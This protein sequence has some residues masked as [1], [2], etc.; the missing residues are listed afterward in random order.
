MALPTLLTYT[1]AIP[2]LHADKP[3]FMANVAALVQPMVDIQNVLSFLASSAF[4][5][6]QAVGVQLDTVGLWIGRS[7]AVNIPLSG[8]YFSF[9]TPNLGFDQGNWQG[10]F[11]PSTGVTL[12]DDTTYRALLRAK[13]IMNSWDGSAAVAAEA[14]NMLFIN[15]PGTFITIQD[16]FDMSMTVGVSGVVPPA[17]LIAL[18]QNGEFNVRPMGVDITYTITSVNTVPLFG[19]DIETSAISGWDVG[20]WSG[21]PGTTPGQVTGF[22]IVA[23]GANTVTLSWIAPVTGVGPYTYQVQYQVTGASTF[24]LAPV[25]PSTVQTIT[26]LAAG[27]SYTAQ[28]YAISSAGPGNPSS[29]LVFSTAAGAPGQV[30]GVQL[31]TAATA[32][33]VSLIWGVVGGATSYQSLYRVTGT[34]PFIIGP[35]ST[36][37]SV[38]IPGLQPATIYDFVIYAV[39]ASGAGINSPVLTVGTVGSAPGVVVNLQTTSV[40]QTDIAIAWLNPTTGNGPF[41]FKVQYAVNTAPIIYQPFTGA[42]TLTA[43]GGSCDITGLING[44]T[45]LIQVS[46]S[47][48]GGNGPFNTPLNVATSVTPNQ[49]TGLTASTTNPTSVVLTWDSIVNA[50]QYQ[51]QYRIE[52]TI[53]WLNG[54]LVTAPTVTATV[55]NLVAGATYQFLVYAIGP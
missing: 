5:L 43:A 41:A 14:I 17:A 51:V 53:V 36:I 45:Y 16:N 29:P 1:G 11:D 6:D 50:V 30:T 39:N 31:Q 12:L 28:V 32:N 40:G 46:A 13:I 10:Q 4:D 52:G 55:T 20:A 44:A 23:L 35:S 34:T 2:P 19:F 48:L 8:V 49:V 15:S 21:Q 37:D 22:A 54:P 9:D 3:K 27:Q 42:M 24:T 33:S 18:L 25:T 7:R 47:N 38:T 26:G